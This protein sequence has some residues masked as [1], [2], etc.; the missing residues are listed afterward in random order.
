MIL[1]AESDGTHCWTRRPE[2]EHRENVQEKS[3]DVKYMIKTR[4]EP[5]ASESDLM[6]QALLL[7]LF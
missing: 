4:K 6:R 2:T 3:D 7:F 1:P 5:A